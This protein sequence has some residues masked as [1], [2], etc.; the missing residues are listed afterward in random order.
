[1]LVGDTMKDY[2]E[3]FSVHFD[4]LFLKGL[5]VKARKF[6]HMW[7]NV[8]PCPD[9]SSIST[10]PVSAVSVVL[11]QRRK[12]E[13]ASTAL[14]WSK[15]EVCSWEMTIDNSVIKKDQLPG[16]HAQLRTLRL[17]GGAR[18]C[19][20]ELFPL[21]WITLTC[22]IFWERLVVKSQQARYALI[23]PTTVL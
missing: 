12:W 15:D 6:W 23:P 4:L 16:S 9:V 14:V 17:E 18:F 13:L 22:S 20:Q 11:A 5:D 2:P 10:L 7:G 19:P 3:S 8:R 21:S 1:M